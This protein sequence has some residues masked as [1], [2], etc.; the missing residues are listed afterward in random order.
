MTMILAE[1]IY[2]QSLSLPENIACE[3]LDFI[4]F[5]KQR[6]AIPTEII[7]TEEEKRQN[8]LAHIANVKAQWH[9]KP[10]TSRDELYDDSR[11]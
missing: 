10:I 1:S 5:L 9:G 4:V 7:S 2:Q 8:A 11:L 6:Y 3:V